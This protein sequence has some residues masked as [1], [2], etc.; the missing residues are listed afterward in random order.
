MKSESRLNY[1]LFSQNSIKLETSQLRDRI[2]FLFEPLICNETQDWL[3]INSFFAES[4]DPDE[5]LV[6]AVVTRYRCAMKWTFS[7]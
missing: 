3:L 4:V 6:R 7:K 5:T 1:L 2:K